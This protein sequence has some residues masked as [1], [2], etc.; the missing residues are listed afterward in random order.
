[1]EGLTCIDINSQYC[2]CVLAQIN[3]CV[4]CTVLSG[5]EYC[6]CTWNGTC[7]L[8]EKYW[9]SREHIIE[10]G[11][12]S[13]FEEITTFHIVKEFNANSYLLRFELSLD[14][15][16]KL[17]R[18]GAFV[19]FRNPEDP[20]YFNFPVGIMRVMEN[21]VEVVVES[22]G[23]KS[24]KIFMDNSRRIVVKGPYYNGVLGYPWIDNISDS[25]IILVAGGIGQAPALSIA[26]A[27]SQ[28]N[29]R[30]QL[31]VILAPGKIGHLFIEQD[32]EALKS[33][34]YRVPSLRKDGIKLL[35]EKLDSSFQ[36]IV[37]AGPDEQHTEIIKLMG[38]LGVDIP[39]AVTNNAIMCC[40]EGVC[41]SCLKKDKKEKKLIRMCKSQIDFRNIENI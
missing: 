38:E 9:R 23:P 35:R 30:N 40:G 33:L 15:M 28:P 5:K 41:G 32:L 4:V 20:F 16:D 11:E 21:Y 8:Y 36:L 19:F 14:F 24:S 10:I 34:I 7:I 18:A 1:M 12:F 2:P 22:I 13:R 6:E 25:K 39:I 31:I 37:S 3:Q 29:K 26:T 27:I 17:K